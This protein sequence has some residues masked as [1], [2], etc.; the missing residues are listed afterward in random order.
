MNLKGNQNVEFIHYNDQLPI[1]N[2][3]GNQ[4][5]EFIHCNNQLSIMNLKG[6]QNV[7][8]HLLLTISYQSW[9]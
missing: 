8:I 4:N 6:N 3:K 1:M 5:V 9:T 7:E 2:L